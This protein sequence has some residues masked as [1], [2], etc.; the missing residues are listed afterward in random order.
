MRRGK[1]EERARAFEGLWPAHGSPW[2]PA[3]TLAERASKRDASLADEIAE[4]SRRGR[5]FVP[6]TSEIRLARISSRGGLTVHFM[7]DTVDE[8]VLLSIDVGRGLGTLRACTHPECQTVFLAERRNLRLCPTHN[9]ER[10]LPES[11]RRA[12]HRVRDK[13]RKRRRGDIPQALEELLRAVS[14][15]EEF[16]AWQKK[17]DAPDPSGRGRPRRE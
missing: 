16:R 8:V 14:H 5:D 13:L 12:W 9:A 17:W 7:A 6:S 11:R 2:Q 4:G 3:G 1:V 10:R 15:S